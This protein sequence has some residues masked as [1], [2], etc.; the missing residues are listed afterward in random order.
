MQTHNAA[1]RE[2]HKRGAA[3]APLGCA[4][5]G[6]L[7][8]AEQTLSPPKKKTTKKSF[9]RPLGEGSASPYS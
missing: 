4:F 7:A 9:V 8:E 2:K 5:T 1:L 6:S 3:S